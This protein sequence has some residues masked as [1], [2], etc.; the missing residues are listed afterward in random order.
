MLTPIPH[1]FAVGGVYL[2]PLLIAAMVGISL[3]L[4]TTRWLNR[5]RWSQYFYYP[6][7]VSLALMVM[8]TLF[9]GTFIIGA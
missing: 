3:A 1:E 5:H 6:P 2:P 4:L 7:L 8:Y 9:I